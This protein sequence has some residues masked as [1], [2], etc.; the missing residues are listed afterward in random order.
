MKA[1]HIK[2]KHKDNFS[3]YK[4]VSWHGSAEMWAAAIQKHGQ[5]MNLG[6]FVNPRDAAK[7]YDT[8]AKILHGSKAKLN[9]G[10]RKRGEKHGTRRAA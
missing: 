9:F 10:P 5:R 8:A 4:G 7:A 3:G 2:S 6:Y 1:Q